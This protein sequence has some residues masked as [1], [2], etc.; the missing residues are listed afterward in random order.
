MRRLTPSLALA[1]A[2]ACGS[3]PSLKNPSSVG[4][5][6]VAPS[7]AHGSVTGYVLDA[8][9]APIAGAT[10]HLVDSDFAGDA[11]TDADG[12][13]A[14]HN[15]PAGGIAYVTATMDGYSTSMA[16]GL[17][18]ATA[19]NVPIDDAG[20]VVGLTMFQLDGSM[21]VEIVGYDGQKPAGLAVTAYYTFGNTVT[22][23]SPL[24]LTADY[25]SGVA[26]FATAPDPND[27]LRYNVGAAVVVSD[28][29]GKYA[30]T[31]VN[32]SAA[33]IAGSGPLLIT[34]GQAGDTGGPPNV[35]SS[36]VHNFIAPGKSTA[37]LVPSTGPVSVV[38]DRKIDAN[39]VVV[40]TDEEGAAVDFSA[41][42]SMNGLGLDIS[43]KG[44]SGFT[45]GAKYNVYFRVTAA[46]SIPA[47]VTERYAACYVDLPNTPIALRAGQPTFVDANANN[48]LDPNEEVDFQ[49]S[50]P[51]GAGPLLNYYVPVYTDSASLA[52]GSAC[53]ITNPCLAEQWETGPSAT[54]PYIYLGGYTTHFRLY[55]PNPQQLPGGT[56]K[57]FVG[58]SQQ[59]KMYQ[60]GVQP[61]L[62]TDLD[63]NVLGADGNPA[64]DPGG[65]LT[66]KP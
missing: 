50:Q 62:V 46:G 15:V 24:V 47:K 49:L 14:F 58:F 63:G 22:N 12:R 31:A 59:L 43:P 56:T 2:A 64:N 28:P 11:K 54:T 6:Q 19:G 20:L 7:T 27:L 5:T 37:S 8:K 36:N 48:F 66:P 4:I 3:S 44:A 34:L 41:A 40:V 26:T 53:T 65:M 9:R 38:F 25:Q 52:A 39:P 57:L 23:A 55:W 61:Y 16:A 10:A 1:F 60:V 35:V 18:P 21:A 17:V 29:S 30:G 51:V 13:F 33:Q 42:L 32:Y 45:P